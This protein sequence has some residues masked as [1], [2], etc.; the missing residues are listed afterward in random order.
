MLK[1]SS[2][3]WKFP[4]MVRVKVMPYKWI[5]EIVCIWKPFRSRTL[6]YDD[7]N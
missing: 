5:A 6:K 4:I 3:K 2:W 7:I 1:V